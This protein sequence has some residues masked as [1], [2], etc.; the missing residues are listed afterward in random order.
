MIVR[1]PDAA[2]TPT[3]TRSVVQ[4]H[5]P[6]PGGDFSLKI[7]RKGQLL[8]TS[9]PYDSYQETVQ[10]A[11]AAMSPEFTVRTFLNCVM[12]LALVSGYSVLIYALLS[13]VGASVAQWCDVNGLHLAG[14]VPHAHGVYGAIPRRHARNGGEFGQRSCS[15]VCDIVLTITFSVC[16]VPYRRDPL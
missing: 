11:I 12:M 7:L 13:D 2:G 5:T 6:I 15:K 4:Y 10:R 16:T 14:D 9:V 1:Y 3:Y 8:S